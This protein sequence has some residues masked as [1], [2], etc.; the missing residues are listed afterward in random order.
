LRTLPPCGFEETVLAGG[1]D[2]VPDDELDVPE[3]V[4]G[5]GLGD[6]LVPALVL[7]RGPL[8]VGA[9]GEEAVLEE[10]PPATATR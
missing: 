8:S 1:L 3:D 5:D 10:A 9:G 4:L 7:V 6:A 2:D